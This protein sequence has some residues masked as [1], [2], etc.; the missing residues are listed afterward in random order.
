VEQPGIV[1]LVIRE[2]ELLALEQ[3]APILKVVLPVP[4]VLPAMLVKWVSE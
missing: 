2:R 1:L 3:E 4:T